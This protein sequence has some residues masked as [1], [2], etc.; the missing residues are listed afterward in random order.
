MKIFLKIK[1]DKDKL[2]GVKYGFIMKINDVEL[3]LDTVMNIDN[4]G[5]AKV[6]VPSALKKRDQFLSAKLT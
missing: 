5:N 6:D 4:I 2:S 1:I 3:K